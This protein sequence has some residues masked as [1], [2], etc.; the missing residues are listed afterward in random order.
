[1]E[2]HIEI[3]LWRFLPV[4]PLP[5]RLVTTNIQLLLDLD[6]GKLARPFINM[7]IDGQ[8]WYYEAS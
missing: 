7:T 4:F 5:K 6:Q 8:M 2:S 1:M 3:V